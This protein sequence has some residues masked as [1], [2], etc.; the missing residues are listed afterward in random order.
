LGQLGTQR[1]HKVKKAAT[2]DHHFQKILR[3]IRR[4][5][6]IDMVIARLTS[7]VHQSS[8]QAA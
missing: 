6:E 3:Q 8:N 5:F 4:E 2:G 1:R 7:F